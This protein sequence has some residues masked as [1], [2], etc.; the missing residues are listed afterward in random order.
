M[1]NGLLGASK[2]SRTLNGIDIEV[3]LWYDVSMHKAPHHNNLSQSVLYELGKKNIGTD[4]ANVSDPV[5][6]RREGVKRIAAKAGA[7]LGGV[8]LA[9]SLSVAANHGL[10]D[11]AT[12]TPQMSDHDRQ[13]MQLNI[14][15]N[16]ELFEQNGDLKPGAHELLPEN[17]N[18]K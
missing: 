9:A 2:T 18:K 14:A 13:N 17:P 4:L 12:Q 10:F 6:V 5:H 8:G 3:S 1:P 15:N 11:E 7:V 16:P